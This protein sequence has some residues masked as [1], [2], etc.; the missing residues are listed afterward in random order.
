[1]AD[2]HSLEDWVNETLQLE[3]IQ[4]V[5]HELSPKCQQA[6]RLRWKEGLR[7]AEIAEQMDLSTGMVKK[8]LARAL[9]LCQMRLD[10]AIE[11]DRVAP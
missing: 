8:Y 11:A 7:V 5:W 3:R 1:M 2:E 10:R 4:R 6:R 9:A